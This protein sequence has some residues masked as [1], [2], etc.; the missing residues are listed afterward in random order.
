[1]VAS[2]VEMGA[3][4]LVD[5][6]PQSVWLLDWLE[7]LPDAACVDL[8]FNGDTFDFLKTTVDGRFPRHVDEA[9]ALRKWASIAA[10][11][12]P[13][14]SGLGRWL[15]RHPNRHVHFVVGNHDLELQFPAVQERLTALIGAPERTHH[16]G[17]SLEIGELHIEHGQ[18][19]DSLFHV[20]PERPF[21]DF[22]GR[23]LLNLPWGAVALLD[24]A[25]PFRDLVGPLDRLKPRKRVFELVPE[26]RKLTIDA[27]WRYWT[28]DWWVDLLHGDPLKK[29]SW[30]LFKE[31][32]Y[33]LGSGDAEIAPS[34]T[35]HA[36]L[37]EAERTRVWCVGHYH[38]PGWWEHAD[39]KVVF[40]GA[41][42]NEFAVEPDG[43]TGRPIN[44]TYAVFWLD[45]GRV[46]TASLVEVEPPPVPEG[47]A[48]ESVA[49]VREAVRAYLANLG[50]TVEVPPE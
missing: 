29:V 7:T 16:A 21:L 35:W 9:V 44:N 45:D 25:L 36:R 4:G 19:T 14:L 23:Q 1:V 47:Y 13:F 48:L 41:F 15:R 37:D 26:F 34:T 50:S 8:V 30:G 43:T 32:L 18:Q 2:D 5:D 38:R 22:Q 20:D 27:Y 46:R 3:G 28:R 12:E 17:L 6:F 49:S 40:T 10:A 33:R 24:V 39:R 31:V 42:R 11:H